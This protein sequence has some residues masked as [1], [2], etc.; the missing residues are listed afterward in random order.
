MQP[1][2]KRKR[3]E[4]KVPEKKSA[5]EIVKR[6]E[7]STRQM[8]IEVVAH[9]IV[10]VDDSLANK[11]K[12]QPILFRLIGRH[13]THTYAWWP[14]DKDIAINVLNTL[15]VTQV[16]EEHGEENKLEHRTLVESLINLLAHQLHTVTAREEARDLLILYFG[17][18]NLGA[19]K[20]VYFHSDNRGK[21][22]GEMDFYL[23]PVKM[24]CYTWLGF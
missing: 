11:D 18:P 10:S 21:E 7:M 6:V 5:D 2:Q 20:R 15:Y 17:T 16:Y 12:G 19:M 23:L 13:E 4:A 3:V 1:S 24:A 8:A 22:I 14:L 9:H